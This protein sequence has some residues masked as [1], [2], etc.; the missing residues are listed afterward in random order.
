ML[1]ASIGSGKRWRGLC[2]GLW[3]VEAL[4]MVPGLGAQVLHPMEP[5]PSYEVA[6]IKPAAENERF[7]APME[8]TILFAFGLPGSSTARLIGGPEWIKNTR[9]VLHTKPPDSIRD[10]MQ[11]MGPEDRTRETRW[12]QQSLLAERLKLKVHFET[13]EMP[14]YEL[15]LTKGGSKLKESSEHTGGMSLRY[16]NDKHEM[17]GNAVPVGAIVNLLM[18]DPEIG[19]RTVVDKTGLAGNFDVFMDWVPGSAPAG[20]DGPSLFAALA[21]Q[22]GLKLVATRGQVE[23]VVIDHIE[24]PSED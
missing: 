12:M 9:Y 16:N 23:V 19:G 17:K 14:I 24:L 3:L 6:T 1:E 22:L 13:H 11:K 8:N 7:A 4:L 15:V 20:T 5:M 21:E 2:A 18:A 10:A